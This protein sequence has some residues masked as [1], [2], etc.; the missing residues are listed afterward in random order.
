MTT[1][2]MSIQPH[3]VHIPSSVTCDFCGTPYGDPMEAPVTNFRIAPS[4]G[5]CYDDDNYPLDICDRCLSK[6]IA[7]E[8]ISLVNTMDALQER[9]AY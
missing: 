7:G 9:S 6:L 2:R 1:Y 3:T 4:Y 8:E 5:S